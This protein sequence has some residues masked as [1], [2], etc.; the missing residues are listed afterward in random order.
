V[1]DLDALVRR[2][3]EDR[4]MASRFAPA[5]VRRRLIA[6][7][8]VNYEIA[9]TAEVVKEPTLGDIRL[10]WWR[11]AIADALAGKPSDQHEAL[12]ALRVAH[13][14]TPLSAQH[15]ATLIDARRHDLDAAPFADWSAFDAYVDATAGSVM[16]LAVE[17]CAGA[18]GDE[19]SAFIT[20]AAW[21][22]GAVGLLRA[23]PT[24]RARGRPLLPSSADALVARVE[25]E[26][27]ALRALHAPPPDLFPA[28]GYVANA[29]AYLRGLRRNGAAPSPF[30][31]RLRI[32][33]AAAT[34]R[35]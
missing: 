18:V 23:E 24:W 35:V 28:Y 29:A 13:G 2:V 31:R 8:A 16:R 10:A 7:Y 33:A 15:F 26:L 27:S 6:I 20:R 12:A 34:G 17:A 11:D 5:D 4:W 19:D 3:D 14:E 30:A 9:R 32:V 25:A 1:E 21:L 22:W